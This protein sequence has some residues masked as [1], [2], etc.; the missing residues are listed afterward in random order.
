VD[1]HNSFTAGAEATAMLQL[2]L[3]NAMPAHRAWMPVFPSINRKVIVK[4]S[5][6]PMTFDCQV[7]PM[8]ADV[9]LFQYELRTASEM[10]GILVEIAE[11]AELI[12]GD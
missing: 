12:H 9:A 2:R 11:I 3:L 7:Q 4:R 10:V 5:V 1:A 8:D 6:A